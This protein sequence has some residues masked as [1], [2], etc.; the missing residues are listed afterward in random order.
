ML[1]S[2]LASGSRALGGRTLAMRTRGL[3]GGHG[4]TG[5]GDGPY[6]GIEP[7]LPGFWHTAAARGM[8]CVMWLWIFY[9][10]KIDG[11]AFLVRARVRCF[12]CARG[13]SRTGGVSARA[14]EL[15]ASDVPVCVSRASD[16]R[17]LRFVP[18]G[19]QGI[20]GHY[21]HVDKDE[22]RSELL[23][24]GRDLEYVND[25]EKLSAVIEAV[26]SHHHHHEE[27]HGEGHE[28]DA[29]SHE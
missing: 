2:R 12:P 11:K 5:Y 7:H 26:A 29:G 17:T 1:L 10:A 28:E 8:G 18:L 24:W 4:P 21:D 19:P 25:E 23:R 3:A 14:R 6:R 22:L 27:E 9:R 16:R 15:R 20:E 13:G